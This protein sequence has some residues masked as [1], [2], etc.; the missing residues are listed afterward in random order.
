MK[1][2]N[3]RTLTAFVEVNGI[4]KVGYKTYFQVGKKLYHVETFS[5]DKKVIDQKIKNFI[6]NLK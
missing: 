5:N 3:I 4:S 2:E 6:D 1:I